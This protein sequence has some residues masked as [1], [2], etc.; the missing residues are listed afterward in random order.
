M[1]TRC[2]SPKT[3][4]SRR[5][6]PLSALTGPVIVSGSAAACRPRSRGGIAVSGM[7]AAIESGAPEAEADAAPHTGLFAQICAQARR[8]R[9]HVHSNVPAR[10]GHLDA[11]AGYVCRDRVRHRGRSRAAIGL[12]IGRLGAEAWRSRGYGEQP[13]AHS[14]ATADA[15]AAGR[16]GIGPVV[17]E[18]CNG[19]SRQKLARLRPF[20]CSR[21]AGDAE[22]QLL[23]IQ[24]RF[25][26]GAVGRRRVIQVG[27]KS[28][29]P[30]A[31]Q[32]LVN[33]LIGAFLDDEHDKMRPLAR[34]GDGLGAQRVGQLDAELRHDEGSDRGFPQRARFGA[35]RQ[36]VRS[37]PSG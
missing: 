6:A 22:G 20:D 3:G 7:D 27:Y 18:D 23:W 37:R 11:D 26:V 32:M 12:V 13:A 1:P 8:I 10:R 14:F 21:L 9:H 36:S 25:T 28:A 34:R 4:S 24:D 31:A 19:A 2:V 5:S 17:V 29:I 15:H 35:R 16:P 30:E 33:G